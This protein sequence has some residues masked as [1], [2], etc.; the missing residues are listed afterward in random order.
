MKEQRRDFARTPAE[1]PAK[2]DHAEDWRSDDA[3]TGVLQWFRATLI[4][5]YCDSIG[6]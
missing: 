1:G 2:V 4:L 3:F 5:T 6:N